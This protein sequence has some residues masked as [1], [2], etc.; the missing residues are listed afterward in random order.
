MI[1][2]QFSNAVEAIVARDPR[3][4]SDAYLF[5]RDALDFT[6]KGQR[7]KPSTSAATTADSHV[8][9]QQLL[10]GVRLYAIKQYGPM[11][12]TVFEHWRVR[13]CEDIGA[14]VFNLIEAKVFG[15]TDHDTLEDFGGGYDFEEAFRRAV[16]LA[17]QSPGSGA[18]RPAPLAVVH[19]QTCLMAGSPGGGRLDVRPPPPGGSLISRSFHPIV[20]S[21]Q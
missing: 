3:F 16:P 18:N 10:E 9:G 6:T 19:S 4:E 5:V 11:A 8:S 13:C 1:S 7:R 2:D 20:L 15:K 12:F 14:I 21:P 17:A